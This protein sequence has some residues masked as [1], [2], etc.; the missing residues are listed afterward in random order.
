[1]YETS[2]V[3]KRYR[4]EPHHRNIDPQNLAFFAIF[5]YEIRLGTVRIIQIKR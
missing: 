2:P 4:S 5:G 3:W 1:M